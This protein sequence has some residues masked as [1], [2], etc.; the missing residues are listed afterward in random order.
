MDRVIVFTDTLAVNKIEP[1]LADIEILRAAS[2]V[3]MARQLVERS[4]VIALIIEKPRIDASFQRLLSSI[5][6]SFPLLQI[7]LISES[8][9]AESAAALSADCLIPYS[10]DR[11]PGELK[12]FLSSI[13]VTERRDRLRFDWPLQGNLSFDDKNWRTYNIWSL[14]ADG[15]FLE[16]RSSA[17]AGGGKGGLRISF[18]NSR[19]LT[20]C[21]VLDRRTASSR[22]PAGFA[23]RFTKM[24]QD[25]KA[26][27]DRII[28]DALVQTL[29]EPDSE[30]GIPSL[31]EE[32]LSIPDF[33]SL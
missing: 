25:S 1:V 12:I 30:P 2:I 27:I 9:E 20:E 24:S 11:V 10:E 15:A 17:P 28:Q 5:K 26:L 8:V 13:D 7:C 22:L 19:L 21:Q 14:S 31:D 18:Q 32:D 23:V 6:K 4:G 29:L 3:E 16:S 33:E